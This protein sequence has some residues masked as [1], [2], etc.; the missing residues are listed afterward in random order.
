V[1]AYSSA[2]ADK[3]LAASALATSVR[4]RISIALELLAILFLW[5]NLELLAVE[6]LA[7]LFLWQNSGRKKT[8]RKQFEEKKS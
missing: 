7:I 5:Q 3:A 6:L 2:L 1:G 8:I 4:I